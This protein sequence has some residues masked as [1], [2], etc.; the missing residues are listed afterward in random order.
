MEKEFYLKLQDVGDLI[1]RATQRYLFR[2]KEDLGMDVTL[3]TGALQETMILRLL[4]YSH[5]LVKIFP[6]KN[7]SQEFVFRI[8]VYK[9]REGEMRG[10]KIAFLE[11]TRQDSSVV[12]IQRF[13]QNFLAQL[14]Y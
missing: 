6:H 10:V 7:F 14:G 4:D 9:T 3:Q 2:N 12:E 11:A 5:L 8:E 1:Y 13:V